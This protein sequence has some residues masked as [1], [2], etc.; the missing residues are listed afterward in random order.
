VG[1]IIAQ[2]SV[3]NPFEPERQI[4]FDAL[5]DTG[6]ALTVLP[7]AWRER[8]G[9]L[10]GSQTVEMATADQRAVSSPVC[11]PVRI[12]VEGFRPVFS[13]IAFLDMQ[14]SDGMYEPLLGY[15]VLEQAGI[16]VDMLGHR[17]VKAKHMDL[18]QS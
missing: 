14:P 3:T 8:L 16:A 13:E 11:G 17:L 2:V 12:E 5:V 1:R 18:K 10:L 9:A 6:S 4:R 15:I 7:A